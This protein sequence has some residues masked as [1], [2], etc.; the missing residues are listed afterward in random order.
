ML[1]QIDAFVRAYDVGALLRFWE[2]LDRRL[3]AHLDAHHAREMHKMKVALLRSVG[4]WVG[5]GLLLLSPVRLCGRGVFN[6]RRQTHLTLYPTTFH[7]PH[8]TQTRYYVVY[9]VKTERRDKAIEFLAEHTLSHGPSTPSSS[10]GAGAGAGGGARGPSPSGI[11][12]QLQVGGLGGN[13]QRKTQKP[14][15]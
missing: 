14:C 8:P 13:T 4:R 12:P 2:F 1:A 15:P 9:C 3:F 5:D 6:I 7:I 10:A 11:P